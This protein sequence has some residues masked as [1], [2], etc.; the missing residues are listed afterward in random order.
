M[1]KVMLDPTK[2]FDILKKEIQELENRK[3]RLIKETDSLQ[4]EANEYAEKV[5]S[6]KETLKGKEDALKQK[7]QKKEEEL[8]RKIANCNNLTAEASE[9]KGELEKSLR[10]SKQAEKDYRKGA[11]E[12]RATQDRVVAIESR[13]NNVIEKIRGELGI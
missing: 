4:K 7:Y 5:D 2:V 11:D 13:L 1:G 8:D 9:V 12:A 10:L 6:Y 3:I